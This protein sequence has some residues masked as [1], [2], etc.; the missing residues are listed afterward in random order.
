MLASTISHRWVHAQHLAPEAI[1]RSI[2]LM[3]VIAACQFPFALYQAGLLGRQRQVL[4]NTVN[5][6][7]V[8]IRTLGAVLLIWRVAPSIE[9]FFA[10]QAFLMFIQ[11]IVTAVLLR[12]NLPRAPQKVHVRFS[13]LH[14]LW[15]FSLVISGNAILGMILSQTDKILL[16]GLLPLSHFGYYT[17]A[18]SIAAVLWYV[19]NP[20]NVA[21]FPHF[22]HT[23]FA[24]SEEQA[25]DTY[26]RAC[27][28]MALLLL[29]VSATVAS[30][31]YPVIV[32]WTGNIAIAQATTLTAALL[33]GGTTL[34]GLASL[35]ILLG[36]AAGF[37]SVIALTN[38]IALGL[39]E[40]A[41]FFATRHYGIVG[42]AA[43][44]VILNSFYVFIAV[45]LVH[46]RVL[47]RE[48]WPWY[49]NDFAKPLIVA[50]GVGALAR[51]AMPA[52]LPAAGSIAYIA[53]SGLITLAAT[54]MVLP[55]VVAMAKD[56]MRGRRVELS[57]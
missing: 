12:R 44:W 46:R 22:T 47:K 17:L 6:C 48:K 39:I 42:A 10:W 57:A 32:I 25:V 31:M 55:Y 43:V 53:A 3:G 36:T 7:F 20:I 38:L 33:V 54:G 9:L 49:W 34:N 37:P 14:N 41:I 15:K 45:P 28:L 56:V 5:T 13:L 51:L 8:T 24:A 26:H 18:G 50:G 21:F 30:F 35:P 1:M 4:V 23:L 19:I 29:P 27:Q 11:V 16:S 2:L 40:P 52:G